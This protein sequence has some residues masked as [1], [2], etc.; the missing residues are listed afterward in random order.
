MDLFH[1]FADRDW[2]HFPIH[3]MVLEAT[4]LTQWTPTVARQLKK[5]DTRYLPT[6][7]AV[8]SKSLHSN[9]KFLAKHPVNIPRHR[10]VSM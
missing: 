1:H 10:V 8:S 4:A 3:E 5:G 2:W 6:T 7:C 9:D